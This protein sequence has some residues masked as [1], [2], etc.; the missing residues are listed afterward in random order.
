[1]ESPRYN[2]NQVVNLIKKT[3]NR[4]FAAIDFVPNEPRFRNLKPINLTGS[5][6]F[7]WIQTWVDDQYIRFECRK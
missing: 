2:D 3:F 7:T 6:P 4:R 5:N 1:M